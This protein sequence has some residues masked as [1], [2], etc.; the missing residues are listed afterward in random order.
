VRYAACGAA[1]AVP[2]PDD[3]D[4]AM[5]RCLLTDCIGDHRCTCGCT[6]KGDAPAGNEVSRQLHALAAFLDEKGVALQVRAAGGSELA[7]ETLPT[8][9]A[10]AGRAVPA[11]RL[12]AREI[13]RLCRVGDRAEAGERSALEALNERACPDCGKPQRRTG[14]AH[15]WYHVATAQDRCGGVDL[16]ASRP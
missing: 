8:Y 14:E 16:R 7:A 6:W 5:C 11:L 10:V 9:L 1:H 3:L 12:G 2:C 15:A 4:G 13:E